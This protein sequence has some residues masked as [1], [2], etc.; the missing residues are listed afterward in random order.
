LSDTTAT[1][2]GLEFSSNF[3]TFG[4]NLVLQGDRTEVD[5]ACM[6]GWYSEYGSRVHVT[7]LNNSFVSLVTSAAEQQQP[8]KMLCTPC[9]RGKYQPE[10]YSA[11]CRACPLG[12]FGK[13]VSATS[14][15]SCI[16]CPIGQ[17]PTPDQSSCKKKAAVD[18]WEAYGKAAVIV[19]GTLVVVVCVSW[20][21][22]SLITAQRE[23]DRLKRQK[24][25]Q[26]KAEMKAKYGVRVVGLTSAIEI[27]ST[28]AAKYELTNSKSLVQFYISKTDQS[29]D[30]D[31]S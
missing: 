12:R 10:P 16:T 29:G 9:Q 3:A 17:H 11:S 31:S 21:L 27:S 28:E 15:V 23:A 13:D 26:Q 8:D 30:T 19:L 7:S 1:L 6:A 24:K 25:Q 22:L 5:L 18:F 2:V 20:L 4:E 14:D